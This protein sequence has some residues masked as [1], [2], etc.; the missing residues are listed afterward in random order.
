MS[1]LQTTA[2][3]LP[4]SVT[5]NILRDCWAVVAVHPVL[6]SEPPSVVLNDADLD[7]M[8]WGRVTMTQQNICWI[9]KLLLIYDTT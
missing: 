9:I 5:V 3:W 8:F 2:E 1:L 4:H 6:S 7:Y